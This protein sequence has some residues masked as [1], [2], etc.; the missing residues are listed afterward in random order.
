MY[1]WFSWEIRCWK[2]HLILFCEV[3]DMMFDSE[4]F[5]LPLFGLN[6][7]LLKG[8]WTAFKLCCEHI[9]FKEVLVRHK[10]LLL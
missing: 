10:I 8:L 3:S 6:G 9:D 5:D 1:Y 2:Y 7:F 4:R